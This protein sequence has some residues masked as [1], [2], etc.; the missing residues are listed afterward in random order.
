MSISSSDRLPRFGAPWDDYEQSRAITMFNEGQT[1]GDIA[2]AL[3][4]TH[5]SVRLRLEK[6]GLIREPK[7]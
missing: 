1:I 4:R 3:Q 7:P 5:S 6:V 2:R